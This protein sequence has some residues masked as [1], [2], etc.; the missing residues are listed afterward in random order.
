MWVIFY[1]KIGIWDRVKDAIT[2][3]KA[4][5]MLQMEC[6]DASQRE[7]P[8]QTLQVKGPDFELNIV[9]FMEVVSPTVYKSWMLG[10]IERIY[11]HHITTAGSGFQTFYCDSYA[12]D[13]TFKQRNCQ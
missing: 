9:S 12:L 3:K 4:Y 8:T 1:H 11:M 10:I 7:F 6:K 2:L 5:F 13:V